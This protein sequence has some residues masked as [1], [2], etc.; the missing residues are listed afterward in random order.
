MIIS[1]SSSEIIY[2]SGDN[3]KAWKE[4]ILLHLGC[5]DLDYAL[6]KEEPLA[7]TVSSTPTEI[8]LYERWERSN[9]LSIMFI[10]S[11][12]RA[13]IRGSIPACDK[14]KDYMKAIDEQFESLQINHLQ[15][16]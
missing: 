5:M 6:R 4:K 12:I 13:S 1:E 11:R 2:L 14:V 9:R 10:K 8:A 15:A 16:P 3:H 7:P